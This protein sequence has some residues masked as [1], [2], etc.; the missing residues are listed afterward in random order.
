MRINEM[1]FTRLVT[2]VEAQRDATSVVFLNIR[3]QL[4]FRKWKA[5][6]SS[7]W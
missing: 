2:F 1:T 4:N 6:L 7:V 3:M 5:A